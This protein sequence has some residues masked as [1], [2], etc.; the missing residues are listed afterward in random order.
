MTRE[1]KKREEKKKVKHTWNEPEYI[2]TYGRRTKRLP[3]KQ[4]STDSHTSYTS[5]CI[6]CN[7]GVSVFM[8]ANQM[9]KQSKTEYFI[10]VYSIR[11]H[12]LKSTVPVVHWESQFEIDSM[13]TK[14]I[15]IV[16][17]L[18]RSLAV[19]VACSH[20]ILPFESIWDLVADVHQYILRYKMT[21]QSL[22]NFI[23]S[24]V[25]IDCQTIE[26]QNATRKKKTN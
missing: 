6:S 5:N 12:R 10:D 7:G 21:I 20:S 24:N 18:L 3:F 13:K 25:N 17:S 11:I 1:E 15:C 8:D 19:S 26:Q 16:L 2:S 14:P 4:R 9:L 22:E 23:I